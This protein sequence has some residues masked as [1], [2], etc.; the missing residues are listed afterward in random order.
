MHWLKMSREW[1]TLRRCEPIPLK[2]TQVLC[3]YGR[4]D[5]LLQKIG[6]TDWS[7][8]ENQMLHLCPQIRFIP[9]DSDHFLSNQNLRRRLLKT[10]TRFYDTPQR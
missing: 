6:F 5:R 10:V 7:W 9:L 8:Y 2:K 4:R 1:W 3:A